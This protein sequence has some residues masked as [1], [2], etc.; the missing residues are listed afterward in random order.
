MYLFTHFAKAHGF[1]YGYTDKNRSL[2][3]NCK[4]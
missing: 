3:V 4:T 1:S 2:I